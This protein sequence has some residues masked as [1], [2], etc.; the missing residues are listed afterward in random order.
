MAA[1]SVT[2]GA[3]AALPPPPRDQ[4]RDPNPA[5]VIGTNYGVERTPTHRD[6]P[7]VS[8]AYQG[9]GP[10]SHSHE[11]CHGSQT[12]DVYKHPESDASPR[13]TI[14]FVH[15]GGF[16]GGDKS[17]REVLGPMWVQGDR[18]WDIVSVNYR[19]TRDRFVTWDAQVADVIAAIN[20]VKDNGDSVD[21]DTR[22]LVVFGW[23][24]GGTLASL[25]AT[26]WNSGL[27]LYSAAPRVTAWV[28]MSGLNDFTI[29]SA[30]D[31]FGL[32]WAGDGVIRLG[33]ASPV[34]FVDHD[35]P[36]GYLITGDQDETVDP[37]N[38]FRLKRAA[39]TKGASVRLD[40]VDRWADMQWQPRTVRNHA[41]AGGVN[42]TALNE[43]FDSL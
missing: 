34:N 26:G 32:R 9:C 30:R 35:D 19:L 42:V 16:T 10:Q 2:A 6:V 38:T 3:C 17:G 15:G 37:E 13:G 29:K 4:V 41:P 36:P 12:L 5:E 14:I 43:F 39:E 7:Y 24:A 8:G 28:N 33:W 1:V 40:I 25:A 21:V 22:R 20:W 27:P 23:S 18:G 11:P 31:R